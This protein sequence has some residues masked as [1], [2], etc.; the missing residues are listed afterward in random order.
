MAEKEAGYY[1][2]KFPVTTPPEDLLKPLANEIKAPIVAIE[3]IAILLSQQL[4]MTEPQRELLMRIP[5]MTERLKVLLDAVEDYVQER[6]KLQ[7]A[8]HDDQV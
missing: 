5:Q 6:R 7:R 8:E 4:E 3:G 2:N 1:P